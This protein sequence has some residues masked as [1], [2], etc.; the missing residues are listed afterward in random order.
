[1]P[2][3]NILQLLIAVLML[4]SVVI[5]TEQLPQDKLVHRESFQ[6]ILANIDVN[7]IHDALHVL[8]DKF[9]DGVFETDM[10]ALEALQGEDKK[11]ASIFKVLKRDS[12]AT[13]SASANPTTEAAIPTE[14]STEATTTSESTKATDSTS[15]STTTSVAT[16]LTTQTSTSSSSSSSSSSSTSTESHSTTTSSASLSTSTY[17]STTTL[18][19]GT[20]ETVT[21]VT[22]V[23]VTPTASTATTTTS[24]PGLQTGGAAMNNGLAREVAAMVGG[25]VIVAMAL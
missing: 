10:S 22:V 7:R 1:M 12:N 5:A 2:R 18:P 19:D 11:I 13:A 4:L 3:F 6:D 21:A 24:H 16:T 14:S 15:T 20:L 9:Q 25:A 17:K 23:H 8:S